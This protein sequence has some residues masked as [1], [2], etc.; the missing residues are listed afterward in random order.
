MGP[1]WVCY[2]GFYPSCHHVLPSVVLTLLV[3]KLPLM[4][5]KQACTLEGDVLP[6]AV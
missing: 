5:C 2:A 4:T 3:E 6:R 1:F